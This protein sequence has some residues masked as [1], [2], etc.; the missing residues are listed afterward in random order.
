MLAETDEAVIIGTPNNICISAKDIPVLEN[1][2]T[3]GS[4]LINGSKVNYIIKL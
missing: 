4:K 2:M 1:R 3:E